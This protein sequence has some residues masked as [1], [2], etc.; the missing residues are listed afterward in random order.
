M[1]PLRGFN[2]S[3]VTPLPINSK[4]LP[5]HI[6]DLKVFGSDTSHQN[7]CTESLCLRVYQFPHFPVR[8]NVLLLLRPPTTHLLHAIQ[9]LPAIAVTGLLLPSAPIVLVEVALV[10]EVESLGKQAC[11]KRSCKCF[12]PS[13]PVPSRRVPGR[14]I[15]VCTIKVSSRR[16][17]SRRVRFVFA[18]CLVGRSGG[19][20]DVGVG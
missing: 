8:V 15:T 18:P 3:C 20:H 16:V 10:E 19:Q 11:Q 14:A 9:L 7:V 4:P 5:T 6:P 12:T 2:S 17:P 13:R 1:D